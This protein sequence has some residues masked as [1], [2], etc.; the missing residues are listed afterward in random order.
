MGLGFDSVLCSCARRSSAAAGSKP[1]AAAAAAAAAA[2][3]VTTAALVLAE[4]PP[5]DGGK[6]CFRPFLSLYETPF[7]Y[8]RQRQLLTSC[9]WK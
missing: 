1:F 2:A 5:A 7:C 6:G 3:G 4:A 8:D 9:G